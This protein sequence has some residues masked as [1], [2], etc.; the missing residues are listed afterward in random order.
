MSHSLIHPSTSL[1][2]KAINDAHA[3]AYT[4]DMR[5]TMAILERHVSN[6]RL[7]TVLRT[8]RHCCLCTYQMWTVREVCITDDHAAGRDEIQLCKLTVRFMSI[9]P[10]KRELSIWRDR[11]RMRI[12]GSLEQPLRISA[13]ETCGTI[14]VLWK[15]CPLPCRRCRNGLNELV[16]CLLQISNQASPKHG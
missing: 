13:K 15:L 9:L 3:A 14:C 11:F 12:S 10:K 6:S 16:S 1:A 2:N 4:Q 8:D 5:S 7:Q